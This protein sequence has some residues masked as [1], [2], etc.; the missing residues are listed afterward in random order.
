MKEILI[1]GPGCA[2][3]EKLYD[4]VKSVVEEN[5]IDCEIFKVTDLGAIAGFGIMQT[6]GLVVNGE[7]KSAGKLLSKDQIKNFLSGD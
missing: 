6:P 4:D 7:I 3:C 1:L 2:R 5:N